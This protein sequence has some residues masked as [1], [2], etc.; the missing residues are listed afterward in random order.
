MTRGS[1]LTA[2]FGC[3]TAVLLLSGTVTL[4]FTE[5][6]WAQLGPT[7]AP[8]PPAQAN[9]LPLS[10]RGTQAGSVNAVESPV[11]G[12]T[13]SVNTINPSV[14]VQ[15][16]YAG[17]IS[18]TAQMPFSGALSLREAVQRA[19][20]YNLGAVGLGNAV[21]QAKGHAKILGHIQ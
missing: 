21:R 18:S 20:Q 5:A 10:G 15:G 4:V 1:R 2:K 14:Q 8:A 9:Q 13:T 11:P 19:V 17:S 6:A 12:T 7:S 16:A 3:L